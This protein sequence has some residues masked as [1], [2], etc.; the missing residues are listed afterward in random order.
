MNFILIL[1]FENLENNI[2]KTYIYYYSFII[3]F[4]LDLSATYLNSIY[5]MTLLNSFTYQQ[6][7]L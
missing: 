5:N 7:I 6:S 4:S 2:E 3:Y 1:Y